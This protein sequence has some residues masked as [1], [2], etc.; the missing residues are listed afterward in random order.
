MNAIA[1]QLETL[2]DEYVMQL[3]AGSQ[4]DFAYKPLPNKWSKKEVIGHLIDS[5][6]N[7]IRRFIVA[8]DEENP[9]IVYNQDKWVAI[10]DYQHHGLK[11]LI[12]L[13]YLLNKQACNILKN[14]SEEVS[15]RICNAGASYTIEW[16]AQDYI[17]H[18]QHHIH[19]ILNLEPVAYP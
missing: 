4:D 2:I 18:L 11:D 16:M 15:Q 13:W 19:I 6:Q 7:N 3:N 12:Q 17:K 5:A 1:I 10:N 8:Q 9:T 14:I